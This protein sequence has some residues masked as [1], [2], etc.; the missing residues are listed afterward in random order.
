MQAATEELSTRLRE[1]QGEVDA[2]D[3][4]LVSIRQELHG[5]KQQAKV[6]TNSVAGSK[7]AVFMST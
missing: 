6:R 7:F 3:A 5:A 2:R 1:K 4:E